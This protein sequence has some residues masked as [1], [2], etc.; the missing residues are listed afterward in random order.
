AAVTGLDALIQKG[1]TSVTVRVGKAIPV[2]GIRTHTADA[3][4]GIPGVAPQ[5]NYGGAINLNG[6]S[7]GVTT[8]TLNVTD[9]DGKKIGTMSA[10]FLAG[11][12]V[13]RTGGN[14]DSYSAYVYDGYKV[15]SFKGGLAASE[16][17][18]LPDLA[19]VISRVGALDSGFTANFNIQGVN[20][21]KTWRS[22]GFENLSTKYSGFYGSGIESGSEITITLDKAVSGDGEIAWK[23]SLPVTVT[24]L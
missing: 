10:P 2:L 1:Q 24:Y 22:P 5:I 14:R 6:F 12:G 11:A 15:S 20:S 8:L 23:A 17:Q 7:A 4:T 19:T 18:I 21:G 9:A 3:F 16:E 13:S